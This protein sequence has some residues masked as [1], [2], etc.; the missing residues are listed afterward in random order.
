MVI[1]F[2]GLENLQFGGGAASVG[3][4]F[5]PYVYIL[6]ISSII[7]TY[8]HAHTH[9]FIYTHKHIYIYIY[10]FENRVYGAQTGMNHDDH[11]L[12]ELLFGL[13][14]DTRVY[15]LWKQVGSP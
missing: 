7:Y 6:Y 5:G 8:I 3:G 9:A 4:D 13:R 10:I 14:K 11:Q 12:K 2:D 1:S 15:F